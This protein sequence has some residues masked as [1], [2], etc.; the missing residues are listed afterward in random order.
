MQAFEPIRVAG[1]DRASQ[2]RERGVYLITGGL[3]G[4]GLAIA[5]YLAR[6]VRARLVLAGRSAFPSRESWDRWLAEH[7]EDDPTSG[8]IRQ[9]RAIEAAGGEVTLERADVAAPGEAAALVARVVARH[10]A[11]HGVVHAAGVPGDGVVQ[12]KAPE[13]AAAVLA[14][15]V[16]GSLA[17]AAALR[18]VEGCDFLAFCS[19]LSAILGGAGQVDYCAANAFQ[20]ALAN[21]HAGRTAPRILS[22][23]WDAWEDAGMWARSSTDRRLDAL[24][25]EAIRDGMQPEEGAL[26]FA[27]ALETGLTQVVVSTRDFSQRVARWAEPV[28]SDARA[29]QNASA[30]PLTQHSRPNIATPLVAP[31]DAIER[32]VAAIWQDLLGIDGVGIHD[33][34]IELGGHSLL[35]LQ[36]TARLRDAFGAECT[37][38]QLFEAPTVAELSELVR[39]QGSDRTADPALAEV[40]TLVDELSE[41]ELNALLARMAMADVPGQGS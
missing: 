7:A 16:D 21:A 32:R 25:P 17:L 9:V 33:N 4:V 35:G 41:Q 19:S 13:V 3:G 10:G 20:D 30:Q 2:L 1:S 15:K 24:R 22:I 28:P 5:A 23:N 40:M 26:A 12:L 36:L 37:L 39:H 27:Y 6:T 38:L 29:S 11:L 8:R 31:R 34:F 14:P 18:T